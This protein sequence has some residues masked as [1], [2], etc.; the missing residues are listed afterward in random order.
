MQKGF[1]LVELIIVFSIM[2]IL[3]A[4]G[5]A[6]FVNYSRIQ[7]VNTAGLEVVTMLN[8]AKSRAFTQVNPCPS[9]SPITGYAVVLCYSGQCTNT[10]GSDYELEAFCGSGG[11]IRIDDKKLPSNVTFDSS[12]STSKFFFNVLTGGVTGAGTIKINGYGLQTK[13]ITVD[14]I[15]KISIQ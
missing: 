6:G 8:V 4:G 7:S 5:F 15:G 13:I 14:G 11:I 2:A 12:V 1:T 10:R 3:A 9:T